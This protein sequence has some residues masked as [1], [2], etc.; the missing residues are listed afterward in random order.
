M[1]RMMAKEKVRVMARVKKGSSRM[2]RWS[3]L[4][5]GECFKKEKNSSLHFEE[6]GSQPQDKR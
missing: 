3:N 1:M 4:L 6:E 2:H 5:F